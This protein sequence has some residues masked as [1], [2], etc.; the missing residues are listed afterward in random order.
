MI[1]KIKL[2]VMF[3]VSAGLN[4]YLMVTSCSSC[5]A[6]CHKM[7]WEKDSKSSHDSANQTVSIDKE[8]KSGRDTANSL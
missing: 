5:D 4:S 7:L 3:K 1:P 8:I 2:H 6:V